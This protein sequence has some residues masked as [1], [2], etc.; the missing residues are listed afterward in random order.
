MHSCKNKL[1]WE[2][3]KAVSIA[4]CESVR[5]IITQHV[6]GMRSTVSSS[7]ASLAVS[8]FS[9]LPRR[10]RDF[11]KNVIDY[12]MRVFN[13]STTFVPNTYHPK[14][15]SERYYLNQQWVFM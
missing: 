12:N 1:P 9:T 6:K 8:C 15:N 13:I 3:K 5:R 14:K 11:Q 10:A 4:Y 2:K 7:L